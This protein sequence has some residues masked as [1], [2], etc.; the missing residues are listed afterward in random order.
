MLARLQPA[1]R[2]RGHLGDRARLVHRPRPQPRPPRRRALRGDP[3]RACCLR[4]AARSSRPRRAGRRRLSC[5]SGGCRA[6]RRGRVLVGPRRLALL[7]DEVCRARARRWVQGPPE[8]LR[9]KAAAGFARKQGVSV[10]ELEVR[11]GFLGVVVPGPADVGGASRAARRRSCRASRFGKS[12]IWEKDGL[13]FSRPVRW[14][15]AKLGKQTVER[16]GVAG[17]PSGRPD[18]RPPLHERRGR[19][20]N[21]R[22]S[23]WRALRAAGVEPEQE[24]RRRTDRRGARRDRRLARPGGRPRGGRLSSSRARRAR[25]DA[26]TSASWSF[27]RASSRPRCSRTSATSRSRARASP[28]SP[29]AATREG[30]LAGNER[31]LEGR[32]EDAHFTFERDVAQGDRGAGRRSSGRSRSSRAPG[33]S[34]T[35]PARLQ[36]ARRRAGRRRGLARGGPPGEGRPGRRARARVPGPRGSHR[37][38]VRPPRRLPRGGLRRDRGAV[39]ARLGRR[40]AAAYRAGA[41][42]RGGR[43]G[44]QPHRRVRARSA[45]DGLPRPARAP[46]R[47]DRPVPARGRGR[48]R[49]STSGRS[50]QRDLGAPRRA[51]GRRQGRPVA[52][53]PTSSSSGWKASS[54]CRSSSC[55]PRARAA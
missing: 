3:C 42:A 10:D 11:D 35:R 43:E 21:A 4:S 39:P 9:E 13:R 24:E 52:T 38:R 16:R 48:A 14:L 12:M 29:T 31:V 1:R 33:A 37:R 27:R 23:T 45:A 6:G 7:V 22:T 26:S 55:A 49:R 15:C 8:H 44:R 34:R 51:E 47:G 41:R 40:P 32:L 20:V 28:S 5:A 18:L 25:R 36:A 53:S 2:A 50:S 54:T 17:L 30:R 19:G 46:P